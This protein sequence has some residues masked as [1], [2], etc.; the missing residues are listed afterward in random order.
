M[1][2]PSRKGAQTYS[3]VAGKR[4]TRNGLFKVAV[5]VLKVKGARKFSYLA[6]PPS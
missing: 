2:I 6:R 3:E 1:I 5:I 4:K